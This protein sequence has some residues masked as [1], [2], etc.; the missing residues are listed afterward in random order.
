M[1]NSADVP[2]TA[3]SW[4]NR[5]V[6]FPLGRIALGIVSI[7]IPF[8]VVATP[9]NLFVTDKLLRKAGALLLTAVVLGAYCAYVR[10]VERRAVRELSRQRLIRELS[11]G[12]LLGALLLSLTIA[13]LAAVGVYR[14]TGINGWQFMMATV[15]AFILAAV[16]EEIVMRGLVFRILE[17]WL[18][19]WSAL[20]LSAILFGL[21]HLL[22]PG[23][24]LAN[25]TSVML[26][27]G[28]LLAAAYMLTRS[29]WFCIG[30]HFAW[31]FT[32]GG[33]FSASVSGGATEG[34]LRGTLVGPESLTGGRFGPEASVVA[35]AL[36]A[37]TGLLLLIAAKR[38][39]NVV[40]PA[41]P[42]TGATAIA[43]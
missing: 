10:I 18:G 37:T 15:P 42:S 13:V 35:L 38:K 41:A 20:A 33:I 1:S 39:G 43:T 40:G 17:Q 23:A 16:L 31:N 28:I 3:P 19:S 24:T 30:I 34:L 5:L 27:A 29:L 36:C 12:V 32:Q 2:L 21:L 7:A 26:E 4:I 22:N 14:I 6:R 8:A 11:G 9:F 25:A